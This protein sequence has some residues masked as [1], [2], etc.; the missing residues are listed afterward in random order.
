MAISSRHD[1]S[2]RRAAPVQGGESPQSVQYPDRQ[3]SRW[4]GIAGLAG[5]GVLAVAMAAGGMRR[6][7]GGAQHHSQK[8][9]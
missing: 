5:C 3:L 8:G 6:G 1:A 4:G 2:A 7:D 9:K